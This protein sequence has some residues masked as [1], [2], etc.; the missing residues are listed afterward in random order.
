MPTYH[1]KFNYFGEIHEFYR[2]TT[3]V[4]RA[5]Y[6]MTRELAKK[7]KVTHSVVKYYFGG[8]KDN[9]TITEEVKQWDLK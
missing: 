4:E 7:M 2:T 5:F 8:I 6:Y 9:Y 3:T 1:G